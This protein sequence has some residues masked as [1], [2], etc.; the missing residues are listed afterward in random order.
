[1]VNNLFREKFF[2]GVLVYLDDIVCF[3]EEFE[4]HLKT[5]KWILNKL[6]TNKLKLKA[7]R[8]KFAYNKVKYLG[9]IVSEAGVSPD[10]HKLHAILDYAPP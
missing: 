8:C 10:P 3:S 6:L 9:Y 2:K 5:L 7:P 4:D 1:M